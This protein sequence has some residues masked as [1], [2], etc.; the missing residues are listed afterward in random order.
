MDLATKYSV[1]K[2]AVNEMNSQ[3]GAGWFGKWI[4]IHEIF[5][6]DTFIIN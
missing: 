6:R 3:V 2:K 5:A 4:E 1:E